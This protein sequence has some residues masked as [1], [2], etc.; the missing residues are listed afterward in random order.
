MTAWTA[1]A[2]AIAP[3]LLSVTFAQV[4]PGLTGTPDRPMQP[5]HAFKCQKITNKGVAKYL[6]TWSKTYTKCIGGI[7]ACVWLSEKT[8][9]TAGRE[10]FVFLRFHVAMR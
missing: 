6:A 7:A 9:V 4:P 8:K 3:P 5:Q 1:V 10:G 2:I